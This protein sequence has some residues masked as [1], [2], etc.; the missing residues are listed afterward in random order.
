MESGV[1]TYPYSAHR[2][3]LPSALSICLLS[4]ALPNAYHYCV[5]PFLSP[6]YYEDYYRDERS[7]TKCIE[8][9][10]YDR[11]D[12]CVC[13]CVGAFYKISA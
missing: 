1:S 13:V 8:D 6:T 7:A 4:T 12:V 11:Q 9:E 3:P 10:Y 5:L 2:T